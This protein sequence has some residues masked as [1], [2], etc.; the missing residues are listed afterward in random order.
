MKEKM[1]QAIHYFMDNLEA[2][3]EL[4]HP[5]DMRRLYDIALFACL[6]NSG[7]PYE[8]MREEFEKALIERNLNE[9]RFEKDYFE[10]IKTLEIAY[11]VIN[12]MRNKIA[13]PS[14]F[15]F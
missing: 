9:E 11:D 14:D 15:R 6:S 4:H 8:E 1:L 13:I 2:V 10:Y 3:N 12:R 7:V 5:N